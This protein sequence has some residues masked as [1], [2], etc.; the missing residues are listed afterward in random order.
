MALA[1]QQRFADALPHFKR[2]VR[3]EPG[4][5]I[6]W[7]NLAFCQLQLGQLDAAE[8]TLREAT[9]RHPGSLSAWTTLANVQ[10]LLRSPR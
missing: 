9:A 8:A 10:L 5:P 7:D 2:A 4:D 6:F 1:A 3:D